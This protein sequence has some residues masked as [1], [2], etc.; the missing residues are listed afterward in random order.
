MNSKQPIKFGINLSIKTARARLKPAHIASFLYVFALLGLP[1][2]LPAQEEELLVSPGKL[3]RV[4]NEYSG[5]NNCT[6]CHTPKTKSVD[7]KCLACHEELAKRIDAGRGFHAD[8]KTGCPGCHPDHQGLE[9]SLI[10]WKPKEF[11][12]VKSGYPLTGKHSGIPDCLKCHSAHNTPSGKPGSYLIK[13]ARCV[14]CHED[15]HRGQFAQECDKCHPVDVPF[16]VI[17]YDHSTAA[18]ALKGTHEKVLCEKCH[19]QKKWAGL[20]YANCTDCHRDEHVP[21]L[22]KT[23]TSCH[24]ETSWKG[25]SYDH[26]R[27]NYP[28]RGRHIALKCSQC[29]PGGKLEKVPFAN[30]RDCHKKDPH[31]GQFTEDCNRCHDD[32]GFKIA[33]FDHQKSRYPL[34]GKHAKVGCEKCHFAKGKDTPIIYKPI[35]IGCL[36]C[37]KDVHLGQFKKD[38]DS[39]HPTQGFESGFLSFDHQRDSSYK[40]E[41]THAAVKCENCHKKM[42]SDFPAGSSETVRYRPLSADC[43]SCHP[44]FHDGQLD[45]GCQ[46]CH[47]IIHFKPAPGFSHEKT[48]YPLKGLHEKVG[49][50]K[51]HP[52]VKATVAGKLVD[53]PRYKPI[54]TKCSDCHE[55]FDHSK[56]DYP[57]T[58]K[59]VGVD[60][61]ACHNAK[62]PNI[63]RLRAAQKE[64][65]SCQECHSYRHPGKQ[66][67]CTDCHNTKSWSVD[68][69]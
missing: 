24:N 60:C 38:C 16:K 52:L 62:T 64:K 51:C 11:D 31:Q 19:P 29:H 50:E 55:K 65:F 23:C 21:S 33:A 2:F 43:V 46:K 35:K 67:N 30:C 54:K 7:K 40:L 44:D 57:L 12:H 39:C 58:G 45:K 3:S 68:V 37:H 8:K 34:A 13:S 28:L 53:S 49:C 25:G 1:H 9:F 41:E 5:L 61:G 15:V 26:N 18:Y 10:E 20:K 63:K 14:A 56:S 4:H 36:D 47:N 42:T 17:K 59:H 22:G 27:T 69:F 6:K 66:E 32:S 48:S